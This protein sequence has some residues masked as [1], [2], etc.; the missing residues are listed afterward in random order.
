MDIAIH[1]L[2]CSE[3]TL[4]SRCKIRE[5][6]QAINLHACEN[7]EDI[8]SQLH[9]FKTGHILFKP[10]SFINLATSSFNSEVSIRVISSNKL[11]PVLSQICDNSPL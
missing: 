4:S 2:E 9:E 3:H 1:S 5:W 11:Q 7:L 6:P 8:K 10:T